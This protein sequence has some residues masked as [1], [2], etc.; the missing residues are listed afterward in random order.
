MPFQLLISPRINGEGNNTKKVYKTSIFFLVVFTEYF[1]I[2]LI[3]NISVSQ[4]MWRQLWKF[5]LF[6]YFASLYFPVYCAMTSDRSEIG[7]QLYCVLPYKSL[8]KIFFIFHIGLLDS[9]I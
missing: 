6:I 3:V 4:A 1:H 2:H 7:G 5:L 9:S 8:A